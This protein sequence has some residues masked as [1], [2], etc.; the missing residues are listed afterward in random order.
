MKRFPTS[1]SPLY[2]ELVRQESLLLA[3]H[4]PIL[5]AHPNA[6]QDTEHYVIAKRVLNDPAGEIAKLLV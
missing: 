4:S 2:L 3:T 6:L 1:A 5:M